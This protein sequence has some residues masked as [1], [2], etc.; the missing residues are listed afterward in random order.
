M[1]RKQRTVAELWEEITGKEYIVAYVNGEQAQRW[2]WID[3]PIFSFSEV[4]ELTGFQ[5]GRVEGFISRGA[6]EL[7]AHD[8]NP[9]SG[10]HI[11]YTGRDVLKLMAVNGLTA[12]GAWPECL[13]NTFRINGPFDLA[14]N[15]YQFRDY[16]DSNRP[17]TIEMNTRAE[18]L[19]YDTGKTDPYK[20]ERDLN[21]AR[22]RR[23]WPRNEWAYVTFDIAAF[24]AETMPMLIRFLESKGIRIENR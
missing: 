7:Q 21:L 15:G 4:L 8:P 24:L 20:N 1:A 12:A 17:D 18:R 5:R 11:R 14:L 3:Y 13:K 16:S 22:I 23:E 6:L 2:N 10:R 19:F 9:G